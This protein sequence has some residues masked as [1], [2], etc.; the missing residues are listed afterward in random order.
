LARAHKSGATI[1]PSEDFEIITADFPGETVSLF[2][3][4]RR[5]WRSEVLDKASIFNANANP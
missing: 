4:T 5:G 1:F 3:Q 2:E